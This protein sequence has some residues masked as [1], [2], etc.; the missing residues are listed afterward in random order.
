MQR[1]VKGDL[2][3]L[4]HTDENSRE[5]ENMDMLDGEEGSN[6]VP[7]QTLTE[8]A[9]QDDPDVFRILV[10]TDIHLGYAEK[11][12]E[13]A[14]DSFRNFEYVLRKAREMEVDFLLLGGDLFHENKPS[15][16]TMHRCMTLLRTY[17]FG[18]KPVSVRFHRI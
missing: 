15:K 6:I 3:F 11:D 2:S 14:E 16:A 9:T 12:A 10:A 17:C 13:I 7:P 5:A 4:S 8:P 1:S 18:D